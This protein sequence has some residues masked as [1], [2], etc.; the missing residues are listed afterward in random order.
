[1]TFKSVL[2][3]MLLLMSAPALTHEVEKG[4]NGGRVVDAGAVHIEL[5]VKETSIEVFV[6]DTNDKPLP[7]KGFKGIAILTVGG[8]AHRI[9]LE[10]K[11]G[12]RLV[13]TAPVKIAGVPRGV[14]QLT[15]P[16]GKTAQ[17]RFK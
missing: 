11:N 16:D 17:A 10:A 13:G 2:I 7:A 4:P 14:V 9:V 3:A 8:K 5:A 15:G 6:S 1:M 12:S